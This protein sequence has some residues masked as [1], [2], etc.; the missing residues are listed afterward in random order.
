MCNNPKLDFV[1]IKAYTKFG[2]ILLI[3]SQDIV[4]KQ[5]YDGGNDRQPKSSID[6][7]FQ[8]GA[9]INSLP[10]MQCHLLIT[11]AT[12]LDPDQAQQNIGPDMGPNCLTL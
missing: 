6:P 10:A 1:N 9:I 8:S 5:N 3:C 4:R 12:S 11:F 7:L 2:K